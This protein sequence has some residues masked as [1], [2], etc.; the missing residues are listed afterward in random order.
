MVAKPTP[1]MSLVSKTADQSPTRGSSAPSPGT[2]GA[3]S[4]FSDRTSTGRPVAEG[5][6]E[7]TALSSQV[8]HSDANTNT[9]MEKSVPETLNRVIC[10]KLSHHNFQIS[11]VEH[12]ERVVSN[13]RQKLCR[14]QGYKMLNIDFNA[15]IWRLFMSATMKAA[16]HLGQY[17]QEN[18]RTTKNTDFEKDKTL[19]DTSQKLMLNH[20]KRNILDIYD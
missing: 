9:S 16:V 17:Y 4:S 6:N 10:T 20:E 7:N 13:V 14:P 1:M 5:W 12:L 18:L 3:P 19:F 2:L 8:W 15:I 11:N